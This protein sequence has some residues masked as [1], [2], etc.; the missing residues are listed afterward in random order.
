MLQWLEA[1]LIRMVKNS[2]KELVLDLLSIIYP[3]L[4]PGCGNILVT[5]ESEICWSCLTDIEETGFEN[6]PVE[7]EFFFR[8]GGLTQIESA[9]SLYYFEKKSKLQRIISSLK[10]GGQ[11]LVGMRLGKHCAHRFAESEFL[12]SVEVVIPVPLHPSRMRMRGYNQSEE[13]ARGFCEV[14]GHQLDTTSLI[15]ARRTITQT[16]KGKQ[17]RWAAMANVFRFIEPVEKNVLLVD[18]VM[19]TGSTLVGCAVTLNRQVFR[20]AS[21]RLMTIGMTRNYK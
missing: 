5:G 16:K 14:T 11:E 13:I 17:E 10:Y 20:P 12:K 15:R 3:P 2:A 9:A 1:F 7:N 18:D 19:T 4:C 8:V 21:I 6:N